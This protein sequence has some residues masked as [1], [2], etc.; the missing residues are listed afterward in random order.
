MSQD[1]QVRVGAGNALPYVYLQLY[2]NSHMGIGSWATKK[3]PIG[4]LRRFD[5]AGERS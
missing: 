2:E 3:L 4:S 1:S 5:G